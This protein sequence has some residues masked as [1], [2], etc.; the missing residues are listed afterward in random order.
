MFKKKQYVVLIINWN[1]RIF[2]LKE[3]K[4]NHLLQC[5]DVRFLGTKKEVRNWFLNGDK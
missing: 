2:T 1:E 4:R 5:H 3:Y